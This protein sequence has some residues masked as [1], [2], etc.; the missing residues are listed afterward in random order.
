MSE[1]VRSMKS[2]TSRRGGTT[3][4]FAGR[5][6]RRVATLT[7]ALGALAAVSAGLAPSA[8]ADDVQSKQWYL[9]AMGAKDLWKVT[10]GKGITVAVIDSG[11]SSTSKS[12]NGRL[13]QGV[14]V[15]DSAGSATDDFDGHGTTIAELI[16]GSGAAGGIKGVAPD[17]KII[18]IRT[19]LSTIKD[20]SVKEKGDTTAKAIRAAADSDAQIINMSFGSDFPSDG[21]LEAVKYAQSKGKLLFAS[22]GN[23]AE[24]ENYIGYPAKYPG[25]VGVSAVD[26]SGQAGKFSESGN[27][28]QLAAPGLDIPE[29]C[30]NDFQSYCTGEGTSMASAITSGAAALIWSKHPSWTANQVLRVMIDTAGRDWPKDK[31][32]RYLGYGLIRPARNVLHGEGSPGAGNINPLTNEKT[33]AGSTSGNTPS[34]SVPASS[35]PPKSTSGGET[36]AAGSSAKS[37][38]G[39]DQLWIVLG[40]A[41]AVVVIGGGAF[42][43]LRAR[44]SG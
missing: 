40:A 2:G 43:V 7:A 37:S 16:A 42:A 10:T 28:V 8:V 12:L 11:V 25:V 9:D 33:T 41:A 39:N 24:E 13:L 18:P 3:A 15:T 6:R 32:S 19:R 1:D 26:K 44:R 29:W 17:A 23:E 27:Y 30:N 34:A 31:P 36:S 5:A 38:D 4:R 14:D 21:G 20:K 35:Q 22:V